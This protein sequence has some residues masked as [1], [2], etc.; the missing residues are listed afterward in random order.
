MTGE[1]DETW[2]TVGIVHSYVVVDDDGQATEVTSIEFVNENAED[3][4][5]DDD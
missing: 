3:S 5:V 2:E 4:G 1:H